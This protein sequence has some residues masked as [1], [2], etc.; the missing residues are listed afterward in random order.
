[1]N[2]TDNVAEELRGVAQRFLQDGKVDVS[3]LSEEAGSVLSCVAS[4]VP[5][6]QPEPV[7]KFY[8]ISDFKEKHKLAAAEEK[9]KLA[10]AMF[11]ILSRRS[12]P[13][14]HHGFTTDED[15]LKMWQDVE[16][17]AGPAPDS[18]VAEACREQFFGPALS[19]A[20]ASGTDP[21]TLK[22]PKAA[23][24]ECALEWAV[25]L[26]SM[27]LVTHFANRTSKVEEAAKLAIYQNKPEIADLLLSTGK[28]SPKTRE[29]C[30]D[31]KSVGML[32]VFR[33]HGMP[34]Y[35]DSGLA[36]AWSEND[37]EMEA[38]LSAENVKPGHSCLDAIL[39]DGNLSRLNDVLAGGIVGKSGLEERVVPTLA[40]VGHFDALIG[41]LDSKYGK[42]ALAKFAPRGEHDKCSDLVSV[43][44]MISEGGDTTRF[45][46]LFQRGLPPE[47]LIRITDQ[48]MFLY[49]AKK[50]IERDGSLPD[51]V[52]PEVLY[53][54]DKNGRPVLESLA[55]MVDKVPWQTAT[56]IIS[57]AD[58][59]SDEFA[60]DVAMRTDWASSE[61][62]S[63][64]PLIA[65]NS[66]DICRQ[67]VKG[68]GKFDLTH[69]FYYRTQFPKTR[70]MSDIL[71]SNG[72]G[73]IPF[74][75]M[76][77]AF[78][79]GAWEF[80]RCALHHDVIA[81][82]ARDYKR[83]LY[84]ISRIRT[85]EDFETA[86]AVVKRFAGDDLAEC[87]PSLFGNK[88]AQRLARHIFD[89]CFS[90][91]SSA[92]HVDASLIKALVEAGEKK[93]LHSILTEEAPVSST[94]IR[95]LFEQDDQDS[96]KLVAKLQPKVKHDVFEGLPDES[97]RSLLHIGFNPVPD[98]WSDYW[99]GRVAADHKLIS[100]I[101]QER[102]EFFS[103]EDISY[104]ARQ[105]LKRGQSSFLPKIVPPAGK[106]DPDD[107]VTQAYLDGSLDLSG[108][109]KTLPS[110]P[111]FDALVSA[112]H[113][114]LRLCKQE[115]KKSGI[116]GRDFVLRYTTGNP[117]WQ[118]IVRHDAPHA[119]LKNLSPFG[120]SQKNFEVILGACV[121]EAAASNTEVDGVIK[122]AFAL[123]VLFGNLTEVLKAAKRKF[124]GTVKTP[125][126]DLGQFSVPRQ[127]TWNPVAWRQVLMHHSCSGLNYVARADEFEKH[128]GRPPQNLPEVRAIAA[129]ITYPNAD[130]N[131]K[132]AEV[133]HSLGVPP[134]T[135]NTYLR[136]FQGE[137]KAEG[138]PAVKVNGSD[139]GCPGYYLE[140]LTYN[141]I[142]GPLLGL[143]TNCCQH[144]DGAASDAAKHGYQSPNGAFYVV[145][146]EDAARKIVSQAWA[147]RGKSG[148]LVFDS[149]ESLS[150]E[151]GDSIAAPLFSKAAMDSV[152][153]LGIKR[154]LVG[155]GGRTPDKIC[156]PR[157]SRPATPVDYRGYRDSHQQAVL[158]ESK[159]L[160][161][162]AGLAGK[163]GGS[164]SA[165]KT[166][167]LAV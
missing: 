58:R 118:K 101:Q 15:G 98:A 124:N 71:L 133:C 20:M 49:G 67:V 141:A 115:V 102:P 24:P 29:R 51:M 144:L 8:S 136:L 99:G 138:C 22:F 2:L 62:L 131:I 47:A 4:G 35:G 80:V 117:R 84:S 5:L 152:G 14:K 17:I 107:Q 158:A 150:D 95:K 164:K 77:E 142:E 16:E 70:E 31:L 85:S 109:M 33:K 128:L 94:V 91:P 76:S 72:V 86:K 93:R 11:R 57:D 110:R 113:G 125:L 68:G 139:V 41:F 167:A 26:D 96:L 83:P 129:K 104:L 97:A 37:K 12:R 155:T 30:F 160:D 39:R 38:A 42:N 87:L 156:A 112:V 106:I 135:F 159:T 40:A 165:G 46:A 10:A 73:K 1:M 23:K 116:Q 48:D 9:P 143:F 147:W 21:K 13:Q 61:P 154:V 43:G 55:K 89:E 153:R 25:A 64:T 36:L 161:D 18:I 78:E 166:P 127:A 65:R 56:E 149:I 132:L 146:R 121:T 120:F 137:K 6:E 145:R 66:I 108:L 44:K 81:A 92:K 148:E 75:D 59:Y 32:K 50:F 7:P 126:H 54:R 63:L 88:G 90:E 45:D 100:L 69:G 27:P 3:A 140:K 53:G 105:E 123:T 162:P 103:P 119:L 122:P 60:M 28:V 151:I 163:S 157:D 114:H 19:R 52:W 79:S 82:D 134:A 130:S 74:N 34:V 111:K